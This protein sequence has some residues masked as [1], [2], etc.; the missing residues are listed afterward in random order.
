MLVAE[1]LVTRRPF[2]PQSNRELFGVEPDSDEWKAYVEYM[3][4]MVLDGFFSCI[5]C[6]LK[7][8]LDN[9]GGPARD[10]LCVVWKIQNGRVLTPLTEP[11][12][13]R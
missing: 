12:R 4:D 6:S 13:C 9:T 10:L 7:F 8:F 3:D 1:R 5:E 11:L 2:F